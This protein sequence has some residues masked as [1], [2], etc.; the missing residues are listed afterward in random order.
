M[1]KTVKVQLDLP[2]DFLQRLDNIALQKLRDVSPPTQFEWLNKNPDGLALLRDI[3]HL[4]KYT[5]LS[6]FELNKMIRQKY[7]AATGGTRTGR[8]NLMAHRVA[9]LVEAFEIT[10][11][12]HMGHA[13]VA[14]LAG[15]LGQRRA[16]TREFIEVAFQEKHVAGVQGVEVAVEKFA[17]KLVVE[18]LV[19]EL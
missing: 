3:M 1:D 7:I 12:N 15:V 4:H 18:L 5:H 11:E 6:Q 16:M 8:P 14:L 17:G 13:R 10:F 19:D 2:E 9:A